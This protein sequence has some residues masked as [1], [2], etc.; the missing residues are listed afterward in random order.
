MR[1][2]VPRISHVF[3]RV[4]SVQSALRTSSTVQSTR[5]AIWSSAADM[6]CAWAPPISPTTRAR[7]FFGALPARWWRWRRKAW[8]WGQESSTATGGLGFTPSGL[9]EQLRASGDE[10]VAAGAGADELDGGADELADPLHVVA[11]GL[12]GDGPTVRPAELLLPTSE[13]F[14]QGA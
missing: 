9:V 8:T 10:L 13:L 12:W 1:C 5:T 2:S 6:S 3:T 11:A 7:S 4:R 14:G